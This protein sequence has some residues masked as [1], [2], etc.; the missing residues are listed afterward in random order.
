MVSATQRVNRRSICAK[1]ALTMYTHTCAMVQTSRVVRPELLDELPQDSPS[2]ISS[3]RDLRIINRML[4]SST[5]FRQVL[6]GHYRPGEK[7]LEIGAGT[8]EL[9][10]VLHRIVPDLAGLDFARRPIDWPSDA[11][12]FETD[13][14]AFERWAVYPIVIGNLFFHHFDGVALAQLGAILNEHAR[15]IVASEPLRT[16]RTKRLFSLLCPLIRAHPVTRYDGCVSIDAGF[17]QDEL[18]RLLCL[19]PEVWDWKVHE[20]WIGSCRM[21]AERR[22]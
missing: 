19:D 7:V 14:F 17:R 8:G 9:G 21:V 18:P 16:R 22:L 2:A 1:S 5:W 6:R 11:D 12:W 4:G 10:Q 15:V 20:T 3:R 13:V